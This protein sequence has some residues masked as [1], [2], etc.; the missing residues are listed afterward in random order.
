[1]GS[2]VPRRELYWALLCPA[3]SSTELYCAPPQILL[4]STVPRRELY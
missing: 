4:G 2:T 1:M 3:A